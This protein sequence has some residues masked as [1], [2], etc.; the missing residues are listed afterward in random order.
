[1]G[2][3]E[4]ADGDRTLIRATT[5]NPD[6]YAGRLAVIE[7]SFRVLGGAELQRATTALGRRLVLAAGQSGE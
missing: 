6:W 5:D 1:M 4:P 2:L 7:A 3:L